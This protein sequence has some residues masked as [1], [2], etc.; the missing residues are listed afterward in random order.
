MFCKIVLRGLR[1]S[2]HA[3]RGLFEILVCYECKR[4]CGLMKF[5][6]RE[7]QSMK[8]RVA[9]IAILCIGLFCTIQSVSDQIY[10]QA[11]MGAP[12]ATAVVM[13]RITVLNPLGTPPPIQ[14]K[15]QAPS[16][17]TLDG[18]TIYFVNTGYIGTDRLMNVMMD[19][20]KTHYPKT[21]VEYKVSKGR[22]T[23]VDKDLW[24]EIAEKADAVII[25]LGH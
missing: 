18:K 8:L 24:A 22:M 13:P 6:S 4:F 12:A 20:F 10:A 2:L 1:Q 17:N 21:S 25:G 16:L 11:K 9:A 14:L 3:S 15:P 23:R 7:E 5:N 19:W